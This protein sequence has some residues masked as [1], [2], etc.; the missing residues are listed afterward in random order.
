VAILE[1]DVVPEEW[2]RTSLYRALSRTIGDML[3]EDEADGTPKRIHTGERDAHGRIQIEFG[4]A[5]QE[6]GEEHG[7]V[8]YTDVE[9][10]D[11]AA[12]RFVGIAKKIWRHFPSNETLRERARQR[13]NG[14]GQPEED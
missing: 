2:A 8:L 4:F 14:D 7:I 11:R 10:G 3:R 9:R 5:K 13:L 6:H 12:R 1:D